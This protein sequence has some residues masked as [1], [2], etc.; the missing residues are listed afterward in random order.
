MATKILI[1]DDRVSL[2]HFIAMELQTAGYQTCISCDNATEPSIFWEVSPDLAILNWDLRRTS[3]PE[4]CAQLQ[5]SDRQLPIVALTGDDEGD[6]YLLQSVKTCLTKPFLMPDLLMAIE[7]HLRHGNRK[8]K[9]L[10][11]L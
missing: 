6:C 8:E 2:P 11:R 5:L 9:A 10:T 7:R 1:V 4:V 3:G